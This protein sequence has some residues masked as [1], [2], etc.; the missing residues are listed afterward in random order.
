[1][2]AFG[3]WDERAQALFLARDRLGIKPLL[4]SSRGGRV[5]FASE[6]E[7][8]QRLNERPYRIDAE[9]LDFYLELSYIPAP[10]TIFEEV[11]KLPP[12]HTLT[13]RRGK[14]PR[15]RRYCRLRFASEPS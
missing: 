1:M 14:P 12:G 5:V 8:F 9:A 3:I 15:L 6:L 7:A 11:R 2:F 4:Y 13:I 10:W